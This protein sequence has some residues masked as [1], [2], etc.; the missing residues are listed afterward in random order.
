[1]FSN[2]DIAY[3]VLVVSQCDVNVCAGNF[4]QKNE[5][6]ETDRVYKNV[7]MK[8]S[9]RYAKGDSVP[10]SFNINAYFMTYSCKDF[11]TCDAIYPDNW[12]NE[13]Y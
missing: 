10:A 1:M 6:G 7:R 2:K 9:K 3:G 12:I 5:Q 13:G 11:M 8:T 4:N